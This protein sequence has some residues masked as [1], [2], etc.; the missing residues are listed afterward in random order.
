[1]NARRA[2]NVREAE[3]GGMDELRAWVERALKASGI[4][5]GEMSRRLGIPED[6]ISKFMRGKRGLSADEMIGI[7]RETG[8]APPADARPPQL[9]APE[10][11]RSVV[12]IKVVGEAAGGV[13]KEMKLS[14]E[15]YD[16][17]YAIDPM[18]PLEAV[19]ALRISGSSINRQA[20]DGDYVVCVD[21]WAFPRELRAGDWVAVRRMRHDTAETT[22]KQLR[23]WPG[24][25]ELWPDSTDPEFQAPV[26]W[27]D[28]GE[29]D[30]IEVFAVVLD[31][32][33]PATRV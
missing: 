33:R 8:V 6:G 22:V 14:F 29:D 1:M 16:L 27:G 13:W 5:R 32:I 28:I 21:V 10:P 18:W 2:K 25:W 30:R 23:G 20:R 19:S 7:E 9:T 11:S 4:S 17:A 15:E 12:R 26:R 24:A 31:F 3:R